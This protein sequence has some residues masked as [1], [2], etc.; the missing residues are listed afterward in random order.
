MAWP[1]FPHA[2]C[3][4]LSDPHSKRIDL[5]SRE[6][7]R[8]RLTTYR[9]RFAR[10][11]PAPRARFKESWTCVARQGARGV[12]HAHNIAPMLCLMVPFFRAW[13]SRSLVLTTIMPAKLPYRGVATSMIARLKQP[14]NDFSAAPQL[15]KCKTTINDQIVARLL[16]FVPRDHRGGDSTVIAFRSL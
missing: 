10:A 16:V 11:A 3:L 7:A 5:K 14:R 12:Q 2:H 6:G 8:C 4:T 1:L 9:H 15:F 13:R